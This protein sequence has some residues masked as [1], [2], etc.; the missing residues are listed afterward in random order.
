MNDE[1]FDKLLDRIGL[2]P[3]YVDRDA[4]ERKRAVIIAEE[5][6]KDD[7][8]LDQL[9]YHQDKQLEEVRRSRNLPVE[10]VAVPGLRNFTREAQRF[11]RFGVKGVIVGY[12]MKPSLCY[13][14]RYEDREEGWFEPEELR[15]QVRP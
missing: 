14:V 7:G 3:V 2:I 6:A 5:E 8:W 1:T 4:E 11:R 9:L 10:T 15:S 13:R 12:T